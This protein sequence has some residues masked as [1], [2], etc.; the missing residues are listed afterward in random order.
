MKYTNEST[1]EFGGKSIVFKYMSK[2]SLSLKMKIVDDIVFGVIND[3]TE[4]EPIL[5]DYFVSVSLIDNLT[6][7]SLPES[8]DESVLFIEETQI[9][10]T[11]FDKVDISDI[12][13][14]AKNKIEFEKNKLINKSKLDD[15]FDTIITL[16]EKYASVIENIDTDEFM[17]KLKSI[18]ELSKIPQEK[19][20]NGILEFENNLKKQNENVSM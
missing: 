20:I 15:L 9:D 2:P 16:V 18:E 10:K 17:N 4:Y 1:Y 5:F 11:I 13:D 19:V 14:S 12:I 3:T 7:I 6:N 8:F